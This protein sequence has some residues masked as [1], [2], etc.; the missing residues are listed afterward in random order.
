RQAAAA[1]RVLGDLA[2][3]SHRLTLTGLTGDD[4][5]QYVLAACGRAPAPDTV[6]AILRATEGNAVFVTQVVRL[7]IAPGQPDAPVG[8]S[9]SLDLPAGVQE[10]IRRRI[11]PLSAEARRVLG[12]AAVIGREFEIGVLA[13]MVALPVEVVFFELAAAVQLGA[14]AEIAEQPGAFRFSH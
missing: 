2:R 7:P 10:V 9:S 5:A 12:A 8:R 6:E 3:S 1:A 11:E 14:I 4:V 13:P